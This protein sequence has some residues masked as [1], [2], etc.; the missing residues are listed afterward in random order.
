MYEMHGN[1]GEW[2]WDWYDKDYYANS[3]ADDPQGPDQGKHR[4]IRGGSWIVNEGSCRSAS[5][6]FLTP[7]ERKEYVGFRVARTP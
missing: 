1:A 5:R 4:M 3:P 7:D 6:F 2:C